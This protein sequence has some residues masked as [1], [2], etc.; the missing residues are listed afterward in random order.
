MTTP[1]RKEINDVLERLDES[2]WQSDA[3]KQG[4]PLATRTSGTGAKLLD[5]D[6]TLRRTTP[7]YNK[8]NHK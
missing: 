5:V 6:A 4:L 8:E 3:E 7:T 1:T 2:E